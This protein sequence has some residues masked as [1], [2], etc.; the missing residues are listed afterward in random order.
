MSKVLSTAD[1]TF[2]LH[3]CFLFVWWWCQST[4]KR[5]LFL[6]F[7][8]KNTFKGPFVRMVSGFSLFLS[9]NPFC[10]SSSFVCDWE[11]C[12]GLLG[13]SFNPFCVEL[14]GFSSIYTF[15]PFC[16]ILSVG[17]WCLVFI[18]VLDLQSILCS[19]YVWENGDWFFHL[20][21]SFNP[22]CVHF[23][24]WCLSFLCSWGS[25]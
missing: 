3:A 13:S 8:C 20:F 21:L 7:F 10:T 9:F 1:Y 12:L 19:S 16:V 17:E 22:F 2:R 14:F 5:F 4:T 25:I 18:F 24:E 11:W 23:W 6:C 15:N